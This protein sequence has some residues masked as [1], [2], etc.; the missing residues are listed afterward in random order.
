VE[1]EEKKRGPMGWEL[2]AVCMANIH[3][4]VPPV[5]PTVR[6]CECAHVCAR[7]CRGGGGSHGPCTCHKGTHSSQCHP[8]SLPTMRYAHAVLLASPNKCRYLRK[9]PVCTN[10]PRP[11]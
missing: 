6:V 8:P 2:R 11:R 3:G 7:E 1:E 4:K 9:K 10:T 5:Q